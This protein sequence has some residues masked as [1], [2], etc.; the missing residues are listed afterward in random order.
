MQALPPEGF[1]P[2]H[3]EGVDRHADGLHA[4]SDARAWGVI[5]RRSYAVHVWNRKTANLTFAR[6]SLLHRLHNSAASC[7]CKLVTVQLRI[8]HGPE[9]IKH[10]TY[11]K[12]DFRLRR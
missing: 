1:Y 5:S 7:I 3:W 4:A 9:C 2:I 12:E 8:H 10:V 11:D 6:G